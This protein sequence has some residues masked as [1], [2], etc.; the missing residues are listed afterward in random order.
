M[1]TCPHEY[2]TLG[3]SYTVTNRQFADVSQVRASQQAHQ[4]P[5][6]LH[7]QV[8]IDLMRIS[9]AMKS[10]GSAISAS[11]PH[12]LASLSKRFLVRIARSCDS[13]FAPAMVVVCSDAPGSVVGVATAS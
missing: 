5:C 12:F 6:I 2:A 9:N 13:E 7:L 11:V 4:P 10:T 1:L 3:E 8:V